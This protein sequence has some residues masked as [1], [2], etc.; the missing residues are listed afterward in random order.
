MKTLPMTRSTRAACIA[1]ALAATFAT[2]SQLAR[3]DEVGQDKAA[4]DKAG[5]QALFD[6]AKEL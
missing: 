5:A 2:T 4:Q 3:A 6:Q 1:I